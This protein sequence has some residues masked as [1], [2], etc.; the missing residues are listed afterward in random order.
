MQTFEDSD[1]KGNKITI[2]LPTELD[3]ISTD[4]LTEVSSN[5]GIAP[6][7][8]LIALI[9]RDKL[10]NIINAR[11]R[12]Q[13]TGVSVISKFVRHGETDNNFI[14]S[15]TTGTT[16]VIS[17]GDLSIAH[18]VGCSGNDLSLSKILAISDNNNAMYS[19]ALAYADKDNY[20]VEF[21]LIP[22]SAIHGT[23]SQNINVKTHYI[24][25]IKAKP[26]EN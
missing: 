6:D 1:K 23:I 5:I 16:C 25:I 12:K 24:E 2:N 11:K 17:G 20:F 19:K 8:S 7:Y 26:V 21:K 4:Y 14:K 13:D 10:A 18:H 15:I 9:Y 22:N 3:E